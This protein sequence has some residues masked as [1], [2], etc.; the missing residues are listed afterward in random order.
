[1]VEIQI[2]VRGTCAEHTRKLLS[3]DRDFASV[4]LV[5]AAAAV[6]LVSLLPVTVCSV[7]CYGS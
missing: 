6:V 4:Y 1:M 2:Q 5:T 7:V 3:R